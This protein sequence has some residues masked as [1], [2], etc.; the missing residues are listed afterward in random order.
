M[1]T[2]TNSPSPPPLEAVFAHHY[3]GFDFGDGSSTNFMCCG[4][5]IKITNLK[6][7]HETMYDSFCAEMPSIEDNAV[8]NGN[9]RMN[10]SSFMSHAGDI[11]GRDPT[12][13]L[14][15]DGGEDPRHEDTEIFHNHL[16]QYLSRRIKKRKRPEAEE[17]HLAEPQPW[18]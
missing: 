5:H 16:Y 11:G 4:T 2:N 9:R 8:C 15:S 6:K 13:I 10:I 3:D 12:S 7:H 1:A 18:P 14:D 17:V